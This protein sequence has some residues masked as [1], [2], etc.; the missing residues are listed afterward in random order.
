MGFVSRA[1]PIVSAVSALALVLAG[2]ATKAGLLDFT[3]A[4]GVMGLAGVLMLLAGLGGLVSFGLSLRSGKPALGQLPAVIVAGGLAWF[5]FSLMSSAG[6]QPAIHDL[7]T[8]F[9]EPPAI[10][11]GAGAPRKNPP[12]YVGASKAPRGSGT[13]A[14]AQRAAYPDVEPIILAE[15]VAEAAEHA[16]SV[17]D[18]MGMEVLAFGPEGDGYRVEA[19][20]TSAWFGFKDDFIVRLRPEG[21]ASTRIDLR[22]KSRVG[23]GDLGA[24][25]ARIREFSRRIGA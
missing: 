6:S 12:D 20:A 17:V 24:N 9:S 8:D 11:A 15:S 2:P 19:V 21:E 7:T 1:V 22:S 14:E 5:V 16:K 25:A 13:V 18:K 23:L 4:F 10:V 3:A